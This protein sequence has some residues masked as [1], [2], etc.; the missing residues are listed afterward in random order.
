MVH[1]KLNIIYFQLKLFKLIGCTDGRT[2]DGEFNSPPSSQK[3]GWGFRETK[4][5]YWGGACTHTKKTTLLAVVVDSH[6]HF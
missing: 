5:W 2:D 4:K 6:S 3:C 1:G